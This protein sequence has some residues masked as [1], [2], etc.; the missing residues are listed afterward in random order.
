VDLNL[1]PHF[2]GEY[3][4]TISHPFVRGNN[5]RGIFQKTGTPEVI[6]NC[7]PMFQKLVEPQVRNTLVT[8][9]LTLFTG[10]S[11]PE[12]DDPVTEPQLQQPVQPPD[13]LP[14]KLRECFIATFEDCL[15]AHLLSHLTI[16]GITYSTST[17]HLGNSLI[18]LKSSAPN[19][20]LPARIDF[21]A[22]ILLDTDD[23]HLVTFIATRKYKPS[24]I[25]SDPFRSFPFLQVELW[26]RE[27]DSLKLYL[28][29][30]IECHFAQSLVLWKDLNL[31]VM[32]SLSR[33]CIFLSF[34]CTC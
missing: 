6:L 9:I 8:D 3:E 18:L 5:L 33:V 17:T 10:E 15:P 21:I 32:I 22:Q 20:Y 19:K 1:S 2:L 27:L 31:M 28:L 29:N 25:K 24:P 14:V 26:S 4:T 30:S 7:K 16:S 13:A 11:V 34:F 23:G 12:F